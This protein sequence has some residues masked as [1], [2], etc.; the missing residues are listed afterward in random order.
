MNWSLLDYIIKLEENDDMHLARVLI[1]LDSLSGKNHRQKV[2]GI[3][4]LA[5]LD[6]L[7]RYP[8][9]LERALKELNKVKEINIK[10]YERYSV[11]S[12]MIRFKYGPWDHRY[13]RF[14]AVLESKGLIEISVRGKTVEISIKDKGHEKAQ[15]LA[16]KPIFGDYLA[17]SRLIKSSFGSMSAVRL[18]E[19][20]YRVFPELTNMRWG[21]AIKL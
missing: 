5:K 13:R 18:V 3:T 12:E 20:V 16:S 4:K 7:L 1:L 15:E 8:V 6:F 2:E 19:F 11:E 17:R 14:L 10:N 21:E 9:A